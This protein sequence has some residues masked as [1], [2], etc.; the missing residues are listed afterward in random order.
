MKVLPDRQVPPVGSPGESASNEDPEALFREAKQRR[1]RRRA[2]IAG[3]IVLALLVTGVALDIARS[4]PAGPRGASTHRIGSSKTTSPP[5]SGDRGASTAVDYPP[6]QVMGLA[7]KYVGWAADATGI[8]LT[9]DQGRSWRTITPPNLAHQFVSQ[10]IGAMDAV[11]QRDLW[12]VLEDVPGLVPYGQSANGSDRGQGID[13]STNGGRTWTFSALP[14]CLQTCGANLSVSFVD[15]A[16][17]FATIGP[18]LSGPT[19]LFSTDN[20]GATW[21]RVGGLPDLG[22]ILSGGPGPGAQIVFSSAL[23]GWAVT[24][25]TFGNGAQASSPGGA[26]YR[27]TDG[28]VS[29]S[30]A[31][32]LSSKNQYALPTFFGSQTGVVL[33]NP[34]GTSNQSTSVFVTD[35]GGATWTAHR[36]PAIRGLATYKPKGLGFRFAAIGPAT[37]K[38]DVGS[39]LYSTTDSGRTWTRSVPTPKSNA[40]TVSSVVFSSSRDGM[41]ISLPPACSVPVYVSQVNRCFPTL[42]VTTDGG[43]RWVPVKP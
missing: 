42:T 16:H 25:P 35:N 22:S 5:R 2:W 11:G 38:I 7:D 40:G 17:G 28:G 8:Y 43:T 24:G 1:R 31:A 34:E 4:G 14:G 32:G 39:A 41:A 19:M 29:W 23:D 18:G 10:R 36:V 26:L 9:T 3:G 6:V 20:G 27:T 30:P 21:T 37:W 15:P 13:R 12:L 33:S